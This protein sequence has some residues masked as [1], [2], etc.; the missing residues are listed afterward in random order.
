MVDA[1][2]SVLSIREQSHRSRPPPNRAHRAQNLYREEIPK[3][4]LASIYMFMWIFSCLLLPERALP[5]FF[6]LLLY[7]L[8][9]YWTYLCYHVPPCPLSGDYTDSRKHSFA[10]G[11]INAVENGNEKRTHTARTQH[12]AGLRNHRL[13]R[14]R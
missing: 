14:R 11:A 7:S 2:A 5:A 3:L 6:S 10:V 9:G 8:F 1:Q 4:D 12:A 13:L